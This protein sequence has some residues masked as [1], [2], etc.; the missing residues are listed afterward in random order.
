MNRYI[1]IHGHFYQPPR[2]NPWLEEIEQQDS[3]YPFK[4]WN[5]RITAECYEPNTASRILDSEGRIA[6]I[7]NNYSKISFNFGPTLLSWM[8]KYA[9]DVYQAILEADRESRSSFGGH[10]SALAQVYNHMI[11]PLANRRDKKTQILWGIADFECRFKRKPEGMWLAETAVDLETLELLVESGIKFTILSPYQAQA[12]R[13]KE[14]DSRE[15]VDV[16]GGRID[17]KKPYWCP[18]PSGQ[19]IALF[20]YDGPIARDAAFGDLLKDGDR[21]ARRLL[22]LSGGNNPDPQL[23]HFATDG[24]TYGHH[25]KFTN[26]ALSYALDKI[27]SDPS[28]RLTIYGEFLEKFPPQEE[29]RIFENTAWSCAHGVGRWSKD[30]G[31]NVMAPAGW[32]QKWRT[33]LREAMNWLRDQ[34]ALV[35]K[36]ET[37]A[38]YSSP[39]DLRDQY[40]RVALDRSPE[41]IEKFFEANGL[42]GLEFGEKVRV[43]KLLEMQR[44]AMLMFTSCGWFFNDISGIEPVQVMQYAARAIQLAYEVR[45]VSLEEGYLKILEKAVSNISGMQNGRHIYNR[46]VK[47]CIVNLQDVSADYAISLLFEDYPAE[48]RVYSYR[49]QCEQLHKHRAGKQQLIIGEAFVRST[50]TLENHRIDFAVLH[51]GDLNL[52]VGVSEHRD[53]AH[54]NSMTDDIRKAFTQNDVLG[55]VKLIHEHFGQ[56]QYSFWNLFKNEQ[57]KAMQHIFEDTLESIEAHFRQIY[58]QYYPLMQISQSVRTSLPKAL[59]MVV[60]FTLNRNLAEALEK[61][62]LDIRQLRDLALEINRWSFTRDM[63]TISLIA[64]RR[65]D[66]MMRRLLENPN[67]ASL[68]QTLELLLN[69]FNILPLQLDLW[70]AQNIYFKLPREKSF[71]RLGE[72]LK[73]KVV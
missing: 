18:L 59:S 20:F 50:I 28:A 16:S 22:S 4:D 21:F 5:Q 26:M 65:I 10:G 52:S 40:V 68:L 54:F 11:M 60:E 25:H 37:Q 41:N 58:D 45:G 7:L 17:P 73:V 57:A 70:K 9:P 33:P 31:C 64:T 43:L 2:E 36:N 19:R 6:K 62:P 34:L 71:E 35:F 1:C 46:Y 8:E 51:L 67:D 32:N 12:V 55:A 23:A 29:V 63:G 61:D 38:Y 44:H 3:A 53:S 72:Y 13:P 66:G 39:W 24:E 27:G 48:S 47:P 15:W 69:V 14:A 30:C 42:A 49:V 56:N